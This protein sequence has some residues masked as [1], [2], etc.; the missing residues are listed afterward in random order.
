MAVVMTIEYEGWSGKA[1]VDDSCIVR[2]KEEA[3]LILE[4]IS[5]IVREDRLRQI[6][7]KTDLIN[8]IYE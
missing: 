4:R 3:D 1:F 8:D 5:G 2:E 7:V 6:T